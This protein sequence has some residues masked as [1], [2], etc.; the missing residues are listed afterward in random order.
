MANTMRI[1]FTL[2]NFDEVTKGLRALPAKIEANVIGH[3]LQDAARPIFSRAKSLA[4]HRTGAL[5][6]S[7]TSVLRS[8]PGKKMVI[9]GPDKD[10]YEGGKKTKGGTDRPANYAHL[11][12]FGHKTRVDSSGGFRKHTSAEIK[13][14]N[15]SGVSLPSAGRRKIEYVSPQPFLRPAVQQGTSEAAARFGKSVELG[16]DKELK[17]LQLTNLK[18][19]KKL[20]KYIAS[21]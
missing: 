12:E 8:Y 17:K 3:A 13:S 9:I 21:L 16:L 19:N 10:Y 1:G 6:K 11:I 18:R 2:S 15:E 4:A 20:N 7:I 14:A 5:R